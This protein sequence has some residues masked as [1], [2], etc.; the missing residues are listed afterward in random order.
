MWRAR[1]SASTYTLLLIQFDPLIDF[2]LQGRFKDV[3]GSL[4]RIYVWLRYSAV[5]QLTWQRNYNTQASWEGR[6]PA[7]R[8]HGM[9]CSTA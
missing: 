6:A 1:W 4:V 7:V 9:L 5:R 2:N 3:E 8:H